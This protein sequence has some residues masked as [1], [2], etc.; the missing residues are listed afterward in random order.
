MARQSALPHSLPPRLID[1]N[2]AAAYVGVSPNTFDK[3]VGQGSMPPARQVS[4]KRIAWDVRELDAAVDALPH[5]GEF[6]TGTD[7]GWEDAAQAT[8]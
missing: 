2:I 3:M 4:G 7:D 6:E 1:R 5:K 8:A